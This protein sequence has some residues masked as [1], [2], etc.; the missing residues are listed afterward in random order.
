MEE[1]KTHITANQNLFINSSKIAY[2]LYIQFNSMILQSLH[3]TTTD[4]SSLHTFFILGMIYIENLHARFK[5][6]RH[7]H[8][9]KDICPLQNNNIQQP[10]SYL[11]RT[12]KDK[13]TRLRFSALKATCQDYC[14][15]LL[16][17]L[18]L[19]RNLLKIGNFFF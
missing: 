2:A 9:F 12:L 4:P 10:N 5:T 17:I 8:S 6:T 16:H 11:Q 3:A 19:T 15:I 13:L 14:K 7:P 1:N 18:N